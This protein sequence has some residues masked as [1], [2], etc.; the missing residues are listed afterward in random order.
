MY[1]ENRVQWRSVDSS[2]GCIEIGLAEADMF[3]A[4]GVSPWTRI[5]PTAQEPARSGRYIKAE[6]YAAPLGLKREREGCVIS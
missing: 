6:L 5:V 1:C 3:V 4:S 2:R